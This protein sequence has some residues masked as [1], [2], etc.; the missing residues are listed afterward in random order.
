MHRRSLRPSFAGG[1]AAAMTV[2][3][4]D[5]S[6]P[7]PS[8][9]APSSSR[10][11]EVVEALRSA[12]APRS[13]QDLAQ[14]LRCDHSTVRTA[15]QS[16]VKLRVAEEAPGGGSGKGPQR[17][18][19]RQPAA[20]QAAARGDA[21][22]GQPGPAGTAPVAAGP[23][24]SYV[25]PGLVGYYPYGQQM[26]YYTLPMAYQAGG[27]GGTKPG[28][29]PGRGPEA[30]P[31]GVRPLMVPYAFPQAAPYGAPLRLPGAAPAA[32]RRPVNHG[33][34]G[35]PLGSQ[36]VGPHTPLHLA[37]AAAGGA[38]H[39]RGLARS[40]GAARTVPLPPRKASSPDGGAGSSGPPPT[41]PAQADRPVRGALAGSTLSSGGS[42]D[43]ESSAGRTASTNSIAGGADGLPAAADLVGAS[44]ELAQQ[45]EQQGGEGVE[46]RV[47]LDEHSQ[48][49]PGDAGGCEGDEQEASG[50]ASPE[51][52]GSE[53]RSGS[54][55]S[56]ER[57]PC[58]FF[59]KTGTCAYGDRCVRALG[60]SGEGRRL[61]VGGWV[62]GM[63]GGGG[64]E[65]GCQAV[66]CGRDGERREGGSS[67]V[68]VWWGLGHAGGLL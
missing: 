2:P 28:A 60:R 27:A 7:Y 32:A 16:L 38:G 3:R 41:S 50:R 15:V 14:K 61:W 62:G 47:A 54:R 65:R 44:G 29:A 52:G 59:L 58:A 51:S 33:W 12:A 64:G 35:V 53:Q 40:T 49:Q 24:P 42:S 22:P 39:F 20:G 46:P 11:G 21:A 31:A 37:H 13:V 4:P 17:Y 48:Q 6:G 55:G 34:G 5:F 8:S 10:E 23:T 26:F 43:G 66:L 68:W 19:L 18:R 57:Q 56:S 9:L 25:P 30:G 1:T 45:P 67:C 63:G 36:A